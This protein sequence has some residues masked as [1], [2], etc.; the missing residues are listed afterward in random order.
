VRQSDLLITITGANVT[1]SALVGSRLG[2]AYV[3]QHVGL[4]RLKNPEFAPFVFFAILSLG[5]VANNF[6]MPLTAKVSPG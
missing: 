6:S 5:V 2:T 1:K 4:V 3:S